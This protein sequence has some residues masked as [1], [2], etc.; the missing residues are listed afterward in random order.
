QTSDDGKG[1]RLYFL[2]NEIGSSQKFSIN[3]D[4]NIYT[5]KGGL[6]ATIELISKNILI[7]I[8]KSACFMKITC[9]NKFIEKSIQK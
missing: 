7:F 4:K 3:N 5:F 2:Y 8:H 1:R 9:Y 6:Y